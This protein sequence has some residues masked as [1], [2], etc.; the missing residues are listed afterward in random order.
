M[1][2]PLITISP[3]P[4]C[5]VRTNPDT[6]RYFLFFKGD[7]EFYAHPTNAVLSADVYIN[8]RGERYNLKPYKNHVANAARQY[9]QLDE[10]RSKTIVDKLMYAD[11]NETGVLL[12]FIEENVNSPL[13]AKMIR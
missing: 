10:L 6:N 5:V 2:G 8:R 13:I 12:D 1:N 11:L 9:H 7:N 4:E 3:Y